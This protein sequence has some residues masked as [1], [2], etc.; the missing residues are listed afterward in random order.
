MAALFL[1]LLLLVAQAATTSSSLQLH[2][3]SNSCPRAE[4]IVRQVVQSHFQRDPSVTSGLLRLFFHDCFIRGCDASVLI[5]STDDNIAEKEAPPNL[6]LRTFDVIDD[7]KAAVEKE[8]TGV[9][10]C[11]DILAL[12]TRDGVALAGGAAYDL[13]T[14]RRDGLVSRMGDVII[15]SPLFSVEKALAAFKKINLD[16]VDLTTLLGAHSSGLCHCGFFLERLYNFK[17]SGLP[18]PTMHPSLLKTLQNKCPPH[19][20]TIQNITDD[21]ALSMNQVTTTPF[22]LDNSFYRALLNNK[23]VLQ[24]DQEL[25]YTDMTNK[26]AVKY[27]NDPEVFRQQ[28][29][30]SMIKLGNVGVLMGGEGEIRV[31]CRR[32][33]GATTS[34]LR[35]KLGAKN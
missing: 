4:I 9:V 18:D 10:S 31:D 7:I 15:P 32:I 34:S 35:T 17:N 20:V 22:H 14:G 27:L 13:P 2:F 30:K 6:T 21:I 29:A 24:L 8:C 16:L 11:A 23:V 1:A 19:L 28:F 33:N 26:L 25:A 5:D 12:A 3:Y